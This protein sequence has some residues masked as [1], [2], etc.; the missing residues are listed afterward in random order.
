[1]SRAEN[2]VVEGESE[3]QWEMANLRPRRTGLPMTIWVQEPSDDTRTQH[4]PR[5]KAGRQHGD[6]FDPADSVTVTVEE[7]PKIIGIGLRNHD[8]RLVREF[9]RAN[10]EPLLDL[11]NH[12]IDI[13]EFLERMTPVQ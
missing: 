4:G 2:I 1:M 13:G 7:N 6:R 5:I 11:W 3:E 9:V 8:Q 12:R 10:R